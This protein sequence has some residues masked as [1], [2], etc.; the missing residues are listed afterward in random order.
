MKNREN[1]TNLK[2]ADYLHASAD[3]RKNLGE[4]IPIDVYRL[5]AYFL[6]EELAAQLQSKLEVFK[7]GVLHIEKINQDSGSSMELINMKMAEILKIFQTGEYAE[8]QCSFS[9]SVVEIDGANNNLTFKEIFHKADE[10]MYE[11]KR[12]NKEKY[13]Q[14]VR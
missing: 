10:I 2:L 13:P 12:R 5:L 11:C 9:Y 1:Q 3:R 8:Y 4:E 6:C 7:I 14:L